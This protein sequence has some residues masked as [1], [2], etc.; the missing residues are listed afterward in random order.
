M[1]NIK[2]IILKKILNEPLEKEELH[3]FQTWI[4]E[5]ESNAKLYERLISQELSNIIIE[6]D[7]EKFGEEMVSE[8]RKSIHTIKRRNKMKL[9][10]KIACTASAAAIISISLWLLDG[11]DKERMIGSDHLNIGSVQQNNQ[12]HIHSGIKLVTSSGEI[13]L[14]KGGNNDIESLVSI[15]KKKNEISFTKLSPCFKDSSKIEAEE[16]KIIVPIKREYNVVLPDGTKVWLNSNSTLLFPSYFS[17]TLRSVKLI[18]EAYFEVVKNKKAPFTVETQKLNTMVLGTQ[19]MVSCYGEK[20]EVSLI[21]GS[22]KVTETGSDQN[23]VLK[24]GRGVVLL[25]NGQFNEIKINTEKLL[26]RK[27]GLILFDENKLS[28]IT[29]ELNHWYGVNFVFENEELKNQTFYIKIN[30]YDD[31]KDIMELLKYTNKIDYSIKNNTITIK[32]CLPMI[33]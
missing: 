19:F 14:D 15:N 7:K 27:N 18:G 17:D 33:D 8:F 16:F 26:A 32:N 6:L 31:I 13:N 4:G 22:V 12:S 21:E 30:R 20:S 28:D 10:S 25:A 2:N 24:P 9:F 5:N 3:L 23:V 29:T 1:K 11:T